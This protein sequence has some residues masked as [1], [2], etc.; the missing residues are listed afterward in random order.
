[1]AAVGLILGLA[2]TTRLA[3]LRAKGD[4]APYDVR[5]EAAMQA[6]PEGRERHN[7]RMT[8]LMVEV[9]S[10]TVCYS[11]ETGHPAGT[12]RNLSVALLPRRARL[13]RPQPIMRPPLPAVV[14]GFALALGFRD[15]PAEWWSYLAR[16][17]RIVVNVVQPVRA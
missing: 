2:D 10:H 7:R 11:V 4:D 14:W 17:R 9:L 12:C 16:D 5:A 13:Y 15:G 8:G 3:E 1:M 6:T